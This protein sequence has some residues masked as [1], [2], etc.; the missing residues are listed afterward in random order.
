[1]YASIYLNKMQAGFINV[2]FASGDFAS[3][4]FSTKNPGKPGFSLGASLPYTSA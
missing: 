4:I 3:G 1:L 2:V